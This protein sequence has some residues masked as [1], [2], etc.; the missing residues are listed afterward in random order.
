MVALSDRKL[1]H[2]QLREL[3]HSTTKYSKLNCRRKSTLKLMADA[4][5]LCDK[6][7]ILRGMK[8]DGLVLIWLKIWNL[9]TQ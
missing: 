7:A 4:G 3:K 9:S 5:I 8:V 6:A 2:Q 1:H